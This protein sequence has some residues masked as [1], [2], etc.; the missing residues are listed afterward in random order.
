M[1]LRQAIGILAQ[2]LKVAPGAVESLVA[3]FFPEVERYLNGNTPHRTTIRAEVAS[4]IASAATPR[5]VLAHSLGS[6]VAYEALCAYPHIEVELLVTLGSPLA[7][8]IVVFDRLDPTHRN[9]SG[10][11]PAGVRRWINVTDKGDLIAIPKGGIKA[12][13]QDVDDDVETSVH[14]ADFHTVTNYLKTET[15]AHILRPHL[16]AG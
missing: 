8:P 2:H 15:L 16:P 12:R 6:V 9:G 7:M 3:V 13:F 11:R 10:Q 14:W 5:I 1:P 4:T